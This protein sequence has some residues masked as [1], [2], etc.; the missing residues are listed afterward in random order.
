MR[1]VPLE[2]GWRVAPGELFTLEVHLSGCFLVQPD[3]RLSERRFPRSA[4]ADQAD[5]LSR[6]HVQTHIVDRM[7]DS[8]ATD[9]EVFRDAFRFDQGFHVA[10]M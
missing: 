5:D 6:I 2:V 1:R 7:H 4:L 8:V 3:K 9:P 10:S